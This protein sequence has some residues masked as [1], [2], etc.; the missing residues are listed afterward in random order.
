MLEK[1]SGRRGRQSGDISYSRSSQGIRF[2]IRLV[3][4]GHG[5]QASQVSALEQNEADQGFGDVKTKQ[6]HLVVLRPWD[7]E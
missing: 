3:R 5:R 7:G 2:A 4:L 1:G 6:S